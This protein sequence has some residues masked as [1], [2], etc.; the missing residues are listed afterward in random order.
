MITKRLKLHEAALTDRIE[1]TVRFSEVDM[2]KVAWHGS[3]VAFLEDGR[4]HFGIT[5]PGVGYADYFRTGYVAPVV[6]LNIDYRQSLRC[7]DRA[8]VETRYIYSEGAKLI[9]EY[10]VYRKSD[11]AIMAVAQ[12]TQLFM[13]AEGEIQYADPDFFVEWKKRWLNK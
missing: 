2:M 6:N 3:Y 4:E 10:V 8:I 11:M 1:L 13:T 7:G 12:T 9:F 5:Y